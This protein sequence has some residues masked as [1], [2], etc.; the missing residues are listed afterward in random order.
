MAPCGVFFC[1]KCC[2][3]LSYFCDS[4]GK[5]ENFFLCSIVEYGMVNI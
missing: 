2:G 4:Y 1:A 5:M 3:S